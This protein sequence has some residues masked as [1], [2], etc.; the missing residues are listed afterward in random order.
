MS[1]NLISIVKR[2]TIYLK[3]IHKNVFKSIAL[4]QVKIIRYVTIIIQMT[5]ITTFYMGILITTMWRNV[6]IY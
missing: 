5:L 1:Q 4:S 3:Y 6:D 2:N